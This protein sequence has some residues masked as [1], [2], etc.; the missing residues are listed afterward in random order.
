MAEAADNSG[1]SGGSPWASFGILGAVEAAQAAVGD[2][3]TELESFTKFQ[4][5][6]DELIKDLKGSPAD[7]KKLGQEPLARAQFGG[8]ANGFKEAAGLHT[9]YQTVITELETLSQLLSDSIEG[10][11]IAVLKSHKGYA[12][13]DDD[14]KDRMRAISVATEKHYGGPYV[15]HLPKKDKGDEGS[16]GHSGGTSDSVDGAS[17]GGL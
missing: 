13:I 3:V 14:I 16:A 12:N 6:V 11:G 1:G 9:S 4:Q 7:S 17:G 2:I 5:R 8:G 10:M 15:P